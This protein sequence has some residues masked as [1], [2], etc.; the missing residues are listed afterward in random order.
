MCLVKT[1]LGKILWEKIL[2]KEKEY[3]YLL[4]RNICCLIKNLAGKN[5]VKKSLGQGK[6]SATRIILLLIKTSFNFL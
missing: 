2:V 4:I 5:P 6:K 1:L 3:T